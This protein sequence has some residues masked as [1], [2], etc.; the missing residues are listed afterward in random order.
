MGTVA[1]AT[2]Q[3]QQRF[4][5]SR[6]ASSVDEWPPYQPKHYTTLAFIHNKGKY[7]DAVRFSV[8][9]ELAVAGK[10]N[11]SQVY[12]H[13]D[14]NANMTKS[15][16]D[17]FL[18]IMASD[19]SLVDL[20]I[21][22]EG[23][24]GIGKTVL[25]KEIAYQWANNK[26][27]TSKKLL[28]L[29]F[30]RE[31]HQTQLRTFEQLMKYIYLSSKMTTCL[32]DYILDTDGKDAVI[33]FDG[34]DE[35]SEENRKKCIIIDIINRRI[36]AKSCLVITSRPTASSNLH[37]SVDRRVEIVG[38]TEEDRLDY[39]QSALGN[40]DEQ[41]KAVQHYLRSNPTINALCYIPLNM[42]ILLCL[43]EDGID[44]FPKI[45]TEM[46]KKFIEMTIVRFIKKYEENFNAV[47]DIT[48]LAHPHDKVFVELAK[49][50][51]KA[52]KSDKIVFTLPEINHSCPNLTMT[53]SNWNGLGLLKTV[54]CFSREMGNDQVTFHFLHFS[55][56]EYMAAWYISKLSD[57]K[58][59]KLLQKTFWKHRYYNIWIMYVGITSGSSFALRH[60]LSG[61]WFQFISKLSKTSK[62]SNKYLK[63][64]LKCLHLFQ[65]LVEAKKED[66]VESAKQ[67]FQNNQIDLSDQTLLPSDLNTLGFFLI[68]SIN[69][70]WDVLNL[71][72][73]NIGSNGINILCDRFLDADNRCLLTIKTIKFSNNQLNFLSFVRMIALSK[74]WQTSEIIITDDAIFDVTT[75]IAIE[76][77]ILQS[78]TDCESK[79][80]L[81][82]S[83]IFAKN[84]GQVKMLKSLSKTSIKAIYLLNCNW[85]SNNSE[86]AELLTLLVEQK[87][88]R[89]HIV[90]SSLSKE[91]LTILIS[92]CSNNESTNLFVYDPTMPDNIADDLSD[93]ILSSSKE[94]SGV[95][96]I[97]SSSKIQGI[98]N[99]CTLS[100]E[101]SCLEIFNLNLYIKYL[102]TKMCSWKTMKDSAEVDVCTFVELLHKID[103]NWHLKI[104]LMENDV[105]IVHKTNLGSIN[106]LL[107]STKRVHLSSCDITELDYDIINTCSALYIWNMPNDVA[108]LCRHRILQELPVLNE[109]FVYGSFDYRDFVISLISNFHYNISTVLFCNDVLV[110]L[111]PNAQ[112]IAL[113][114]Q[115]QPLPTSWKQYTAV[116]ANTIY[117]LADALATFHTKWTEL[118]FT[119]CK[120]GDIECEILL[121]ILRLKNYSSTVRRLKFSFN[122]LSVSGICDLVKTVLIWEVQELSIVGT[123]DVLY[124]CLIKKLK[125]ENMHQNNFFLSII[126]NQNFLQMHCNAAWNKIATKINS[127]VSELYII[128]C[129]LQLLNSKE[130]TSRLTIAHDLSRLCILNG[131]VSETVVTGVLKVFLY[132]VVEISISTVRIIGD[133]RMVMSLIT[134]CVDIKL[135]LVLSTKH[136]MYVCNITKYQLRLIQQYFMNGN[137]T[138]PN[139]YGMA[140]VRELEKING[141]V[142]MCTFDNNLVNLVHVHAKN[143]QVTGAKQVIAA[144]RNTTTLKTIDIKNY[145]IAS[146]AADCL[147]NVL[148]CNNQ[149]Q[150][151]HLIGNCLQTS[152]VI[153][154]TKALCSI[155]TSTSQSNLGTTITSTTMNLH[156]CITLKKF[157][158]TNNN[159]TDKVTDD[160]AAVISCNTHLQELDLGNNDLQAS[161]ITKVS[162]S[163]QKI[164]S[165]IKLYINHNNIT[166]KAADDIAA[167]IS[168]NTRLQELDLD[169]NDL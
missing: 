151:L 35:L 128:N 130:I 144:L 33:I 160:I 26:L 5:S 67:L 9:Q 23:A 119:C 77:V 134:A 16:S 84:V 52:L 111:H 8:A 7:T 13:S 73:C 148:Q 58:Q 156:N 45:Q 121:R 143:F 14:S 147:A 120:I 47:I 97:V 62:V 51:Y 85:K 126:Y 29:V 39:I 71:S 108:E 129:D 59:I 162:R 167:V 74:F 102:N 135:N 70:E 86:T 146:E 114:F 21:L 81:I 132:K 93:L 116:S 11:T 17:I 139:C 4:I 10:I 137:Q 57:S 66:I 104:I 75:I 141:D 133:Y 88:E 82:G 155:Q 36:L 83:L 140:L 107:C 89:V 92:V 27:L 37:G 95:M 164:S 112:Q 41:V 12:K 118:D 90:G 60:F 122:K 3:L 152:D 138:Q 125:S 105:V 109:L 34:F 38:F 44:R 94:K 158:I 127:K 1:D 136:W 19:G 46:Y 42:T 32:T 22:I 117:Q 48:N 100:S 124:E 110:T 154:I 87:L 72:N 43:I 169:N 153:K 166:D 163:L 54:Q 96:L 99:T 28:L 131:T 65:C 165:L 24:P 69:K 145:G 149:L 79:L 159:I 55:V 91:F 115:L 106:K 161:G 123:N 63:H 61:N 18:P 25:A 50:A 49:L 15:I 30:L 56:Q 76:D 53:S 101:L 103:F 78:S 168:Y 6:F 80:V 20:H 113:V 31:C 142:K 98:V 64:K 157:S 2:K 40:C 150:E 68:R